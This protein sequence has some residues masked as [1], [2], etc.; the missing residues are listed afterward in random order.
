MSDNQEESDNNDKI[1]ISNG[2]DGSDN[3]DRAYKSDNHHDRDIIEL[4][5][6]H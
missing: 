1:Y 4:V 6:L 5:S 2:Q 3:N